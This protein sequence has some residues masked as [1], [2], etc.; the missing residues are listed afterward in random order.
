MLGNL[1]DLGDLRKFLGP[2][3]FKNL[4][5]PNMQNGAFFSDAADADEEDFPRVDLYGRGSDEIIAVLEL[6]GLTSSQDVSLSVTSNVL[7]VKG[8]ITSRFNLR[9][10][11]VLL[12]ECH[13]GPFERKIELPVKVL[14]DQ[15]R[16]VYRSG[17][18][19][20][21]LVR[22]KSQDPSDRLVPI[23]FDNEGKTPA[24]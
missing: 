4:P 8:Q 18:L 11:T 5:L 2:D 15:V 9:D 21:D 16:A 12:S 7:Y 1:G 13:H 3:F 22:D 17:L 20:V 10:D 19:I 24:P 23:D 6:P 14:A